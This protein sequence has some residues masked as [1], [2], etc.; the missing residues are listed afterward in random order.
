M[1]KRNTVMVVVLLVC[2]FVLVLGTLVVAQDS[3]DSQPDSASA[4]SSL[5]V[6]GP[7]SD[8]NPSGPAEVVIPA[9]YQPSVATLE[10]TATTE[11]SA[12]VYFTPQ[13]ENTSTTVL[14]LYN[15]GT[16]AAT[17][18]LKTF[19]INGGLTISTP[20]GL[21]ARTM[22]RI[23]GDEPVTIA[24]SWEDA[25][26]IDFRTDSTYA[27]VTLPAGV[28]AEGFVVWNNSTIY[29]PLQAAPV[30]PLR[31]SSDPSTVFLPSLPAN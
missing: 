6:A 5:Q 8:S 18:A 30:L 17:V 27:M 16:T 12:T 29:D 11:A 31:F 9:K 23:A 3:G 4:D 28:K 13:D 20:I 15:T 7:N 14:F 26:W 1:K 10:Q 19:N 22:V 25:V 21:P 24:P 2:T